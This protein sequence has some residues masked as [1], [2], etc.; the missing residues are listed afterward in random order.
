MPVI[1]DEQQEQ[2]RDE[3]YFI[4]KHVVSKSQLKILREACDYLIGAM[5]AEMDRLG[6]D[7]IHISHRHKRYHIAKQYERAP[8]LE[9]FVFSELMA[10]I[11]RVTLG[12]KAFL[13]YDQYVVKAAEQGMAFSWHQDSGYLGFPH[14]PYVTCWTAVDDMTLANGTAYV[15]PFSQIGIRTLVDHVD[16]EITGDKAGYFGEAPGVPAIVPAGSVVVF[17]SLSFHRSGPNTTDQ[18][19][20]AYVT[21]YSPEILRRPGETEPMHLGVPFLQNGRRILGQ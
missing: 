16:D 19:R 7:H 1:T 5:H 3:G 2:F 17:S 11:C 15:M 13:F 9:E 6:T 12:E 21:Q 4:L 18:M 14:T 8:R 20:R 10:E